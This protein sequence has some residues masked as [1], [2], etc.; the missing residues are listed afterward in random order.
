VLNTLHPSE[1][2][3]LNARAFEAAGV[4]AFQMVDWRPGLEQLFEDGREIVT[5]RGIADLRERLTHY[6]ADPDGRLSIARNGRDRAAADHTYALRLRLLME[7]VY[8]PG[9]GYPLPSV[10]VVA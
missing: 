5:F 10:S 8:G 2:W 9:D 1:I 7:T 3:G 6:L 4:G